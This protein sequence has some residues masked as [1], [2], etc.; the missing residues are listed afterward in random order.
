MFDDAVHINQRFCEYQE[1]NYKLKSLT[2]VRG[3]ESEA[4]DNI[5]KDLLKQLGTKGPF[6]AQP[7]GETHLI[8]ALKR[9][10]K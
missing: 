10:I 5:I 1:E 9:Q 6:I 2:E 3:Q 7:R 4:K 8:S